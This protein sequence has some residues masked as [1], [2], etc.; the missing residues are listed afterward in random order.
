MNVSRYCKQCYQSTVMLS[1]APPRY[2][3]MKKS[4]ASAGSC[5]DPA[6]QEMLVQQLHTMYAH[7]AA[8]STPVNLGASPFK[9]PLSRRI[10]GQ[11][12]GTLIPAPALRCW[13]SSCV[14]SEG[15]QLQRGERVPT[16]T[17]LPELR[18]I[19]LN[20]VNESASLAK[21]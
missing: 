20:L 3:G 7:S 12:R 2:I 16:Q 21:L 5:A 8:G 14:E 19:G 6:P 11:L 17:M 10:K 13:T 4:F 1:I 15:I 9:A 18:H